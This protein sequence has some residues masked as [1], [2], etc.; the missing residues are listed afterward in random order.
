MNYLILKKKF[1]ISDMKSDNFYPLEYSTYCLHC[2]THNIS[3]DMS[4]DI[5]QE[6]HVELG[7]QHRT[8]KLIVHLIHGVDFSNF[9]NHK[10]VQVL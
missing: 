8:L 5:L 9:V 7:R 3:T 6:L 1:L 10:R 2:N 4:F